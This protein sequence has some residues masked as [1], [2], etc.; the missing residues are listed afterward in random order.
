VE[1]NILF[2]TVLFRNLLPRYERMD[3]TSPTSAYMLFRVTKVRAYFSS[4]FFLL[5]RSKSSL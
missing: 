3:F 5:K 2:Y 1:D 4:A